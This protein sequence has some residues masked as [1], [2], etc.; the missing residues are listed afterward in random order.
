MTQCVL[1]NSTICPT[2]I[3]SRKYPDPVPKFIV[4]FQIWVMN[5]RLSAMV[6][7]NTIILACNLYL[8]VSFRQCSKTLLTLLDFAFSKINK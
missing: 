1:S 6:V 2:V 8:C 3:C 7:Q 5:T 4:R